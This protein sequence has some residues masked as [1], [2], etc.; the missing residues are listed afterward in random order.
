MKIHP[1]PDSDV[2]P[3]TILS[4]KLRILGWAEAE[5]AGCGERMI[6]KPSPTHPG[7]P[8]CSDECGKLIA[9]RERDH[10]WNR[11]QA[12]TDEGPLTIHDPM[13]PG[14]TGRGTVVT[15]SRC[16]AQIAKS[17]ANLYFRTDPKKDWGPWDPMNNCPGSDV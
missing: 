2:A 14:R 8:C 3:S 16:P 6:T 12:S 7:N 15:C 10:D 9:E 5:C 13:A 1:R 4:D 17:G 11:V